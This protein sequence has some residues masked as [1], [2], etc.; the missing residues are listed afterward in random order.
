MKMSDSVDLVE[1]YAE[2]GPWDGWKINAKWMKDGN[3]HEWSTHFKSKVSYLNSTRGICSPI[4]I[5]FEFH[6]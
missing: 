1:D 3:F 2:V 6:I 4:G 5:K